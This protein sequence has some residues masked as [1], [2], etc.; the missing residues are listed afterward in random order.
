[1]THALV[2]EV[3]MK[4]LPV[5]RFTGTGWA[6]RAAALAGYVVMVAAGA[7]LTYLFVEK[8]ARHRL[9]S[10]RAFTLPRPSKR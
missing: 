6:V 1:M 2:Q 8:P 5:D 10:L 4:L 3:A 9:R 7:V